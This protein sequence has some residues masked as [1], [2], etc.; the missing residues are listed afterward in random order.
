[1]KEL[2]ESIYRKN[3]YGDHLDDVDFQLHHKM[4]SISN[5]VQDEIKWANEERK[6]GNYLPSKYENNLDEMIMCLSEIH[7]M[8]RESL[9]KNGSVIQDRITKD[10]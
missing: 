10:T 7:K 3:K 4:A 2:F 1:M 5:R 6:R 9:N 8:L